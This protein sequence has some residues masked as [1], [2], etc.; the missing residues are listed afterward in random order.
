MDTKEYFQELPGLEKDNLHPEFHTYLTTY[1]RARSPQ[2]Y[3]EIA[4]RFR[5]IEGEI[6][7]QHECNGKPF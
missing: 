4:S 5:F 7:A 1:I 2:L 3:S 6:Y